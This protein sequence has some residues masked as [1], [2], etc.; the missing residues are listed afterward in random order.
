MAWHS[1][2]RFNMSGRFSYFR[3]LL[4][5]RQKQEKYVRNTTVGIDDSGSF[6]RGRGQSEYF[7]LVATVIPNY[8][9]FEKIAS[10]L[11]IMKQSIAKSSNVDAPVRKR[12]L[13]R[14]VDQTEG[15]YVSSH[16]KSK[17]TISTSAEKAAQYSNQVEELLDRV[18]SDQWGHVFDILF[19]SNSL[20]NKKRER[21]FISM[22]YRVAEIHGK[23]IDWIEM[24]SS[25]NNRS[26]QIIDFPANVIGTSIEHADEV[27]ESHEERKILHNKERK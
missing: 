19:D 25:K 27:H 26:L 12:I 9:K 13:M 4:K 14:I 21:D 1:F 22:C 3:G 18:F 20:I 10:E 16:H 2:I 23:R 6:G 8:K 5:K 15:I 24:D 11:P 7:T 17:M